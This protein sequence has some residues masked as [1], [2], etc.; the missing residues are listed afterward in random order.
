MAVHWQASASVALLKRRAELLQQIRGYFALQNVL[1]V[2]T[3]LLC[4]GSVTDPHL[5]AFTTFWQPGNKNLYLQTSP[6]YAMKRLLAGGCGDIFQICKAFRQD[7]VASKHNPEFTLLEWYRIGYDHHQLM[8]DVQGLLA[9]VG[10]TGELQRLSYRQAFIYHLSID[11]FLI[12]DAALQQL[13]SGHI[14][15]SFGDE[16]RDF[17]LELLFSHLIEPHLNRHIIYDYPLS[18]AALARSGLDAKGAAVGHR[19][20]VF[21]QGVELANGYWELQSADEHRQRFKRDRQLRRQAAQVLID[22]DERFL[23]ALEAGLPSCAGV[24]L[25]VDRLLQALTGANQLA[26]VVSFTTDQA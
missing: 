5:E 18:Q 22:D 17:Y 13:T 3:P 16:S 9:S 11:P 12:T 19:F 10:I 24:A 26:E 2:E 7:P 8:A 14:E 1:E 23:A 4:H 6:E 15:G 21:V 20:E 25:G